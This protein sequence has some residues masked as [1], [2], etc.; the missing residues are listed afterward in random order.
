MT[1]L[2]IDYELISKYCTRANHLP[3]EQMGGWRD[4]HQP[5][6]SINQVEEE[7]ARS[8]WAHSSDLCKLQYRNMLNDKNSSAYD[9]NCIWDCL[10][11]IRGCNHSYSSHYRLK[12]SQSLSY[13]RY[14]MVNMAITKTRNGKHSKVYF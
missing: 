7:A 8:I 12:I 5:D 3:A 10:G 6:C 14:D 9:D 1:G 4:E 11:I 13:I 2:V